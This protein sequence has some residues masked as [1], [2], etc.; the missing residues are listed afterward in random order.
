MIKESLITKATE[1]VRIEYGVPKG[2]FGRTPLS[3]IILNLEK[4][5]LMHILQYPMF[6]CDQIELDSLKEL[7]RR[8]SPP[9]YIYEGYF[10]AL[11]TNNKFFSKNPN[12]KI[13]IDFFK[14]PVGAYV[15]AFFVVFRNLNFAILDKLRK[16]LFT[17]AKDRLGQG[18]IIEDDICYV[19]SKWIEDGRIFADLSIQIHFGEGNEA[20][21]RNAWH[22]DAENSLI[23]L[24]ITLRGNR[25]LHSKRSANSTGNVKEILEPQVTC[26]Y[27]A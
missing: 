13:G 27:K 16:E 22:S 25:T 7:D 26:S 17:S 1:N 2:K 5:V 23:H 20:K 21:F 24:A 4:N 6:S 19:F 9:Y 8:V 14:P 15:R 18:K 3:M 10:H 12:P 11:S